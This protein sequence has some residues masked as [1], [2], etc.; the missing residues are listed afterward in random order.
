MMST[1]ERD[2]PR[3]GVRRA[4]AA[5][6]RTDRR[7]LEV[8]NLGPRQAAAVSAPRRTVRRMPS[9]PALTIPDLIADPTLVKRLV[10]EGE[11]LYVEREEKGS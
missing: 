5:S 1:W 10:D 6:R 3:S 11:T 9:L 2:A 4:S 7:E 8:L